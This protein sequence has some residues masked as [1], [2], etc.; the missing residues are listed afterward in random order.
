MRD[1]SLFKSLYPRQFLDDT[2]NIQ[3]AIK[4]TT[5]NCFLFDDSHVLGNLTSKFNHSCVPN[6]HLD[7]VDF[8]GSDKF[9]GGWTHRKVLRGQELTFDYV[10]KGDIPFHNTMK[11]LHRFCCECTDE[12]ILGNAQRSKIHAD[13]GAHFKKRDTHLINTMVD[14]YLNTKSGRQVS[15]RQKELKREIKRVIKSGDFKSM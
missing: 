12:Y 2:E 9:Y 4:K 3:K 15:N 11:E 6:C 10:N 14:A 7:I 13:I 1:G 8:V 5:Q